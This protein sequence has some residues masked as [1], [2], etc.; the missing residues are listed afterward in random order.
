MSEAENAVFDSK[1]DW[2]SLDFVIRRW[3]A[4]SGFENDQEM[5]QKLKESQD[6]AQ[7]CVHTTHFQKAFDG[8]HYLQYNG[9]IKSE[10]SW[11]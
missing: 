4:Q 8:K 9:F 10:N 5:Y 1:I 7:C 3:A 2:K 6:L 11:N